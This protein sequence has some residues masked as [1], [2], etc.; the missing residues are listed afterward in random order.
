[1]RRLVIVIAVG[2]SSPEPL[3][4]LSP[5]TTY[6]CEPVASGSLGCIGG[7]RW[8]SDYPPGDEGPLQQDDP[9]TVFPTNCVAHIPDCSPF[10]KG[11]ERGFQCMSDGTWS[12]LL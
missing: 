4:K 3:C 8:R 5:H 7:P 12:E 9:E 11:S 6:A 1:M 2:C 10:Y